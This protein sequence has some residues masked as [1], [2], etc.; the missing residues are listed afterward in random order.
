MAPLESGS[1]AFQSPSEQREKCSHCPHSDERQPESGLFRIQ[2]GPR[3]KWKLFDR[4]TSHLRTSVVALP[5]PR[6]LQRKART[7]APISVGQSILRS[8]V[9]GQNI[10][11]YG[12]KDRLPSFWAEPGEYQALCPLRPWKLGFLLATQRFE[13]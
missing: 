10:A 2:T 3:M 12:Y 11:K 9:C 13:F 5:Q 1:A 6:A 8:P 7:V 4:V